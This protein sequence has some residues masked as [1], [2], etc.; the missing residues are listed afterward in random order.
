MCVRRC[1]RIEAEIA[2]QCWSIDRP[3]DEAKDEENY[4]IDAFNVLVSRIWQVG[5]AKYTSVTCMCFDAIEA[6]AGI[7]QEL[8]LYW[9]DVGRLNES[10]Q[11]AI[12]RVLIRTITRIAQS[13]ERLHSVKKFKKISAEA[14]FGAFSVFGVIKTQNTDRCGSWLALKWFEF[15]RQTAH[16]SSSELSSSALWNIASC[17]MTTRLCGRK[18]ILEQE[19][20][21]LRRYLRPRVWH[22]SKPVWPL[23]H[24][25][26][27]GS[28][29]SFSETIWWH[30][31]PNSPVVNAWQFRCLVDTVRD[32]C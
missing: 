1:I 17:A 13:Q 6:Y 8:A 7:Q 19:G 24:C 23:C 14:V 29:Q 25:G 22:Y 9:F 30:H 32:H 20:A 26:G 31:A 3:V 18:V 11:D 2:I 27:S 16:Q 5:I 10:A 12:R 28:F 15:R 4:V 21:R